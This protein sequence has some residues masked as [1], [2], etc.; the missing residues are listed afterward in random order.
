MADLSDE[1]LL[2]DLG[3]EAVAD[4]KV[5][6]S[7]RSAR[8]IA[9]FEEIERFFDKN[10][11]PPSH[12]DGKDIF[13]RLYA[14]RLEQIRSSMECLSVLA[15]KDKH[16]LLTGASATPTNE[17]FG[18]LDDEDLLADLGVTPSAETD[19][20]KLKHVR[21][22]A[23]V[24]AAEEIARRTPCLDFDRFKPLFSKIQ[25]EMNTGLRRA[26]TYKDDAKMKGGDFFIL[27]GQKAYIA[28]MGEEFK[29]D[30]DRPDRR[31]RLIYDN[32]TESNL[33]MR[34][35][36]RALNKDP[37]GRR[38]TDPATAGPLFSGIAEV[39]DS[40]SGTVY[41]LRSQSDHPVIV[42]SRDV[43]H[44][45]GVTS[46]D[47]KKR[48]ANAK[49]DPTFLMAD[50]NIVATYELSNISRSKLEWVIHK[51]FRPARLDIEIKD[52]FGQ[53]VIP[54]EWF[55]VPLFIIDEAIERI[56]NGSIIK[57]HYDP[58][59]GTILEGEM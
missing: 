11:R 41:V 16:G 13:E 49:L 53:P 32:G 35:F 4:P 37:M 47:V 19:I 57:C 27:G 20:T 12:G 6:G 56:R 51:F 50:V 30:Y 14:V 9:G 45:I 48:I 33:L 18:E 1:E 23:E 2:A 39:G 10:G 55:L 17:A 24:H 29:T 43:I 40:A 22:R 44:K 3:V 15:G 58:K 46:D 38:I 5:K 42:K 8:I 34:S 31:L 21:T 25:E 59:T 26:I 36:Q 7:T 52:R 28:D 54:R